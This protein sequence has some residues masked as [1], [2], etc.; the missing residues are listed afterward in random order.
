MIK[1]W[2]DL[3][4]FPV[5]VGATKQDTPEAISLEELSQRLNLGETPVFAVDARER[6]DNRMLV[7]ALLQEVLIASEPPVDDTLSLDL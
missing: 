7:M 3:P 1:V 5:V 6:E 2:S 4:G